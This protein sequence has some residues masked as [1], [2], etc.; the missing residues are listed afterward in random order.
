MQPYRVY[1][2][3]IE[4]AGELARLGLTEQILLDAVTAGHEAA[5]ASTRHHPASHSGFVMWSETTKALR[6]LLTPK[7]WEAENVKGQPLVVSPDAAVAITVSGGDEA[8][9]C[10]GRRRPKSSCTKGS[11]TVNAVASNVLWILPELEQAEVKRLQR[12]DKRDTWIL[13]VHRD[14]LVGKTRSELSR[15]TQTDG[16]GRIADWS[17]RILLPAIDY[18]DTPTAV[19]RGGNES[20]QTGEIRVEIKRKA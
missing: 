3:T 19:A 20:N 4:A 1:S 18:G 14:D 9:G 17:D 16:N 6:D 7:D 10:K 5:A 2:E 13:L 15:P 12:L 8:T 11:V